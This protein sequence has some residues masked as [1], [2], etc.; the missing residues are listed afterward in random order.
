[1]EELIKDY[2]FFFFI[3]G[4]REFRRRGEERESVVW[5]IR[6]EVMLVQL[7]LQRPL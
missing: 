3:G 4:I 7:N 1:M 5:K 6:K 2:R